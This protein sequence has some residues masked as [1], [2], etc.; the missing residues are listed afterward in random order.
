VPLP[1]TRREKEKIRVRD[2][3]KTIRKQKR[4]GNR[5]L[6]VVVVLLIVV[7]APVIVAWYGLTYAAVVDYSFGGASDVRR[8]YRLTAM[9]PFQP[10]TIDI[11]HIRV[12][13]AGNTDITVIVTLNAI[14]AVVAP[15]PGG[16]YG[17]Y[18]DM[19]N[20]QIHLPVA[21]GYRVVTFYVTLPVQA[22]TFTLRVSVA[23]VL[24][25]SSFTSLATSSFASIQPISPTTLIYENT[26]T[27]P[28]DYELT[29]Q[30]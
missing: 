16:Y 6:L 29:Q 25:F 19:A 27:N 20:V 24:D 7:G 30:Y 26:I 1:R 9:S 17:P 10:A 3:P 22:L 18:T 14:N 13:N 4:L 23:R 28:Y 2:R 21:S 5:G 8:S 15:A 12:R 11:T